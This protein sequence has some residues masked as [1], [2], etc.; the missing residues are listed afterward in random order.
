MLSGVK[1]FY[2]NINLIYFL[3]VIK[4]NECKNY[5]IKCEMYFENIA[6][7]VRDNPYTRINYFPLQGEGALYIFKWI[8]LIYTN[9]L[10]TYTT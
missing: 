2:V 8:L 1:Y 4:I 9:I 10:Q 3:K 5:D 6:I 7:I